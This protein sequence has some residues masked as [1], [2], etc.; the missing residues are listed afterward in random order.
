MT[1]KHKRHM[2][3][4]DPLSEYRSEYRSDWSLRKATS[5]DLLPKQV[6]IHATDRN[7]GDLILL[8]EAC[9]SCPNEDLRGVGEMLIRG[10][11]LIAKTLADP[12]SLLKGPSHFTPLNLLLVSDTAR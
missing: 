2:R 10:L 9:F 4:W 6:Y 11:A 12:S 1:R 5:R 7:R 8:Q 3:D